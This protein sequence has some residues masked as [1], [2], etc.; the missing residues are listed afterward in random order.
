MNTK[1]I[2]K[3]LDWTSIFGNTSQYENLHEFLSG[4]ITID[5]F[6]SGFYPRSKNKKIV[7]DNL[8]SGHIPCF[9]RHGK[10]LWNMSNVQRFWDE[11]SEDRIK[12]YI[13]KI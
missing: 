10:K 7:V 5:E 2:I 8:R 13:D 3:S 4:R 6:S 12:D 1:Q 9:I 11:S